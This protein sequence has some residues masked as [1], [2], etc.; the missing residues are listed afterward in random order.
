MWSMWSAPSDL[1]YYDS[2]GGDRDED[3][4]DIC[5]DCGACLD[6]GEACEDRCETN[7][8]APEPAPISCLAVEE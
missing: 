8:P 2:L 4:A 3:E 5:G 7:R 1:E 6:R